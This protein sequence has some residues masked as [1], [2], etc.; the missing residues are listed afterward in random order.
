MESRINVTCYGKFLVIKLPY[1]LQVEM[2]QLVSGPT[3][4]HSYRD[5][6]AEL[7]IFCSEK[8]NFVNVL[9]HFDAAG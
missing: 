6:G 3:H 1:K 4:C 5:K 2:W 9:L 7:S 8:V